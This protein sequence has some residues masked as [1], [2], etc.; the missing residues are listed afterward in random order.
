MEHVHITQKV[1]KQLAMPQINFNL[2]AYTKKGVWNM[3][4]LR[5]KDVEKVSENLY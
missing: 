5:E 4:V 3:N 2:V 1:K